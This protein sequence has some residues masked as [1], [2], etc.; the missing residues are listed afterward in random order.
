MRFILP[1]SRIRNAVHLLDWF[2]PGAN[3]SSVEK[4]IDWSDRDGWWGIPEK[5]TRVLNH[6]LSGN[7]K[8]N[9]WKV[10]RGKLTS[11]LVNNFRKGLFPSWAEYVTVGSSTYEYVLLYYTVTVGRMTS[12]CGTSPMYRFEA[13]DMGSP[14]SS[15]VP[16]VGT[17]CDVT[18]RVSARCRHKRRHVRS[19]A[20]GKGRWRESADG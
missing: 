6:S 13:D 15:T 14:L 16:D 12:S 11:G 17:C 1:A 20:S 9:L 2:V 8:R 7:A 18:Q 5:S 3:Y 19:R 4:S 10:T